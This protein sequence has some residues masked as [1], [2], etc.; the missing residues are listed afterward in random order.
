MSKAAPRY[1]RALFQALQAEGSLAASHSVLEALGALPQDLVARLDDSTIALPK[2]ESALLVALGNPG[3]DTLWGRLVTLLSHKRRLGLIDEICRIT[4]DIE[5]S[6]AGVVDGTVVSQS[7]LE[8]AVVA[9][10][11]GDLSTS[12]RKVHLSNSADSSI[13][14]GFR[15]KLGAT[16]LDAT[17]NNQLQ[18]A[19]KVLLSA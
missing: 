8:P 19:R 6:E 15:V 16:V 5:R 17:I 13:L 3:E 9:R 1:A 4:L 7:P 10:L 18:Q 11:E 12:H 2:R 14:G